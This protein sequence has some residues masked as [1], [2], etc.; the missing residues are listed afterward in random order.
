MRTIRTPEKRDAL[1][2]ALVD[3]GG[4]VTEACRVA[5]V[6]R[7][8]IYGWK[9]EDADF[10][11]AFA[12][13]LDQGIDVMEDEATRRAVSGVDEPV[14]YQG[15]ECGKVRRYSDTLI[16]FLLK[17]RRPE[18]YKDRTTNE[19]V[20]ANGGPIEVVQYQIPSNGRE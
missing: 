4:N 20:G 11:E 2:A 3:S 17:G 12:K 15:F 16:I 14:F 5:N 6:A 7:S 9:A 10:A 8:A 18:K 13:A 19:I 1:L